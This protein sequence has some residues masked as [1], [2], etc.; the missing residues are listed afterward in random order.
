MKKFVVLLLILIVAG[1]G[2]YSLKTSE[3]P[4]KAEKPTIRI[5]ATLPLTG[6][7]AN[8]GISSKNSIAMTLDKWKGKNTK[9]NY[10]VVFE[11]DGFQAR[12]VAN[13]LNPWD[14]Y[15]RSFPTSNSAISILITGIPID[16]A[17]FFRAPNII[18]VLNILNS[19]LPA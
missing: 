3:I 15:K 14:L 13:C 18:F 4:N 8:V 12:N 17:Y 16:I 5:G 7:M 10:E 2:I 6:N 9:Y 1:V 11:D 19:G